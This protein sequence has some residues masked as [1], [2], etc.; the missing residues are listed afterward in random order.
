MV[1]LL[2]KLLFLFRHILCPTQNVSFKTFT[3]I[4]RYDLL[5]MSPSVPKSINTNRNRLNSKIRFIT[6]MYKMMDRVSL[7]VHVGSYTHDRNLTIV[8]R[9]TCWIQFKIEN[10]F[11]GSYS[12]IS[13]KYGYMIII[14]FSIQS[15]LVTSNVI[16]FWSWV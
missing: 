10:R 5:I 12:A 14:P 9:C 7:I 11:I 13:I 8:A 16:H 3:L 2:L 1:V 4:N 6:E 15:Y